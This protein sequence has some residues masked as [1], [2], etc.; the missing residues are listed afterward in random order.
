MSGHGVL[1]T[2]HFPLDQSTSS[3]RSNHSFQIPENADVAL[4][5]WPG[6]KYVDV[7][8]F[9]FPWFF[10]LQA[11]KRKAVTNQKIVHVPDHRNLEPY[12]KHFDLLP[13]TKDFTIV[14]CLSNPIITKNRIPIPKSNIFG[15]QPS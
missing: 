13:E 7:M 6:N 5:I 2:L 8:H 10:H 14:N 12:C 3:M 15:T 9:H 4:L 1:M 11:S